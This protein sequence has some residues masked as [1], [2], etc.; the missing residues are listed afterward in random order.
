MLFLQ[1]AIVITVKY[2]SEVVTGLTIHDFRYKGGYCRV[3][4][5]R[6]KDQKK[7]SIYQPPVCQNTKQS[8]SRY[9]KLITGCLLLLFV[10][11]Y[12]ALISLNICNAQI[13]FYGP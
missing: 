7:E 4:F 5:Y 9:S 10:F 1:F 2:N 8:Y 11:G 12:S 6:Y 3:L 13:Y